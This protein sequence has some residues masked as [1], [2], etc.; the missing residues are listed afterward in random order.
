MKMTLIIKIAIT[1]LIMTILSACG[2]KSTGENDSSKDTVKEVEKSQA[3]ETNQIVDN[4]PAVGT[5]ADNTLTI[6]I[7]ETKLGVNGEMFGDLKPNDWNW[8]SASGKKDGRVLYNGTAG[9][10]KTY[11]H[12]EQDHAI[13]QHLE[14][15]G[16]NGNRIDG[17]E[18]GRKMAYSWDDVSSVIK[19]NQIVVT[20]EG[21][22][23]GDDPSIIVTTYRITP[24][25]K[26]KQISKVE[27]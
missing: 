20:Y 3:T 5:Q 26:F 9:T 13:I 14:S 8:N 18:V 27:K 7:Q 1:L 12:M 21:G 11:Y 22:E 2:G 17:L 15:Y 24:D 23:P 6:D 10:F 19:G 16:K 25:L 4:T